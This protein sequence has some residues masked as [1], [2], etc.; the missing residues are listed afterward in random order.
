L[1]LDA[2][3]PQKALTFSWKVN[4]CKPLHAGDAVRARGE[5]G[6]RGGEEHFGSARLVAHAVAGMAFVDNA[7][8]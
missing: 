1:K 7:L 8:A 2:Y 4:E 6:G 5:A 3:S